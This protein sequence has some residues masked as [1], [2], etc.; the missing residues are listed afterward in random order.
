VVKA[1]YEKDPDVGLTEA[2]ILDRTYLKESLGEGMLKQAFKVVAAGAFEVDKSGK[3]PKYRWK[4][5][6]FDE[7]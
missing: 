2:R 7:G 5:D 1:Q 3:A 6:Q 4:A